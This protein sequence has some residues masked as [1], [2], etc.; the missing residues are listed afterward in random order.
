M[1]TAGIVLSLLFAIG[2]GVALGT[3]RERRRVSGSAGAT[4]LQLRGW[5][6]CER[7]LF[8]EAGAEREDLLGRVR[9]RVPP[10]LRL[11][12][13]ELV[14]ASERALEPVGEIDT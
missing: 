13:E 11:R 14:E 4:D 6:L 8:E 12:H 9:T 7:A 3:A 10:A 2:G 1:V 5:L